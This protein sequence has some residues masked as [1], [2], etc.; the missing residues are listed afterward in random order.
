MEKNAEVLNDLI[1]PETQQNA[2]E[3]YEVKHFKRKKG[4]RPHF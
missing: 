4:L 2:A 1:K 3:P